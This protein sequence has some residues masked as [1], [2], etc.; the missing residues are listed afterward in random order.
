MIHSL[1]SKNQNLTMAKE[2]NLHREKEKKRYL[3]ILNSIHVCALK[4]LQSCL[5]L[6]DRMD[7]DP[8]GSSVH[9]VL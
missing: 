6:W 9:G 3:K 7:C 2:K 8:P 5:T 4:S 1:K